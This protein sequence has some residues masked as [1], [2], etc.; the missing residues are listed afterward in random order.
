MA[1]G[2]GLAVGDGVGL[3]EDVGEGDGLGVG[4]VVA[5]GEGLAVGEAVIVDEGLG[6]GPPTPVTTPGEVVSWGVGCGEEVT[7]GAE[8][9]VAKTEMSGCGATPAGFACRLTAADAPIAL[10]ARRGRP[11]LGS[12]RRVW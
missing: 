2:L 8:P 7:S 11:A 3:G 10:S 5:V 6:D 4:D 1:E 9:S 12:S